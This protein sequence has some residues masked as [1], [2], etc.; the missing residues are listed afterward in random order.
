MFPMAAEPMGVAREALLRAAATESAMLLSSFFLFRRLRLLLLVLLAFFLPFF[1]FFF[2]LERSL[3][4]E[5]LEL[6][7]QATTWQ[8]PLRLLRLRLLLL[9]TSMVPPWPPLSPERPLALIRSFSL[10]C[11]ARAFTCPFHPGS[12]TSTGSSLTIADGGIGGHLPR[13]AAGSK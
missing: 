8:L 5:L 6:P 11:R 7:L 2:L 10:A 3:L 9:P 13:G 1:F 12:S 4:L